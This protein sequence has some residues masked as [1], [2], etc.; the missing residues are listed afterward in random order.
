M[1][2]IV[3]NCGP[4]MPLC[5]SSIYNVQYII[6]ASCHFFPALGIPTHSYLQDILL[7]FYHVRFSQDLLMGHC[8]S[9]WVDAKRK[10]T[11]SSLCKVSVG[12][13]C[14]VCH[15]A[16]VHLQRSLLMVSTGHLLLDLYHAS[17]ARTCKWTMVP[18][19]CGQ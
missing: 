1:A 16:V 2:D 7:D 8:N 3:S 18:P 5:D 9:K 4:N 11:M 17:S 19:S 6:Y 12:T 13:N 14:E 10:G 15:S